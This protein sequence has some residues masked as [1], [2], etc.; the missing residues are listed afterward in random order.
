ML[1]CF[2][3]SSMALCNGLSLKASDDAQIKK[4]RH[5]PKDCLPTLPI[6]KLLMVELGL[7]RKELASN[8]LD[9]SLMEFKRY[10]ILMMLRKLFHRD[11]LIYMLRYEPGEDFEFRELV[12]HHYRCDVNA[13]EL[14]ALTDIPIATFNRKFKKAFGMSAKHWLNKKRTISVLIDLKTTDMTIKEIA[15]KYNLTPNYLSDFC[16]KHL[17]DTP[18]SFRE[19]D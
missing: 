10:I 19:N 14:A 6:P 15:A 12:F 7:T 2:F 1:Y 9:I 11:D 16:K 8:L 5:R 18:A 3:N 4:V 13:Q 17:G